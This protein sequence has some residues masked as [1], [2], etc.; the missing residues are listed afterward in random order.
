MIKEYDENYEV[1]CILPFFLQTKNDPSRGQLQF[2][3]NL[4]TKLSC[5][6]YSSSRHELLDVNIKNRYNITSQN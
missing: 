3:H 6:G 5:K 4:I 2:C 1:D